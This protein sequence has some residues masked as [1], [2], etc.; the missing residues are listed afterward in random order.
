MQIQS[1]SVPIVYRINIFKI[2]SQSLFTNTYILSHIRDR[3]WL[4][5]QYSEGI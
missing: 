1:M 4:I 3:A 5:N 2:Q